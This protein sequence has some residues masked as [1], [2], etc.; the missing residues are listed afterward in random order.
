MFDHNPKKLGIHDLVVLQVFCT[1]I[2]K[3]PFF[4]T[5][6]VHGVKVFKHM[7]LTRQWGRRIKSF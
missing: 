2:I 3:D 4:T 6:E 5:H 1:S 7:N